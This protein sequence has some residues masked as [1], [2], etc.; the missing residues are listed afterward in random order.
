MN[1]PSTSRSGNRCSAYVARWAAS[2]GRDATAA[3]IPRGTRRRRRPLTCKQAIDL[4]AS[5]EEEDGGDRDAVDEREHADGRSAWTVHR[6]GGSSD[7]AGPLGRTRASGRRGV[8]H[9]VLV[10]GAAAQRSGGRRRRTA[11]SRANRAQARIDR[12]IGQRALRR[13]PRQGYGRPRMHRGRRSRAASSA[14]PVDGAIRR[15][16]AGHLHLA[17]RTRL[18]DRLAARGCAA[19]S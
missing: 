8:V 16:T 10:I 1:R 19:R 5:G 11:N 6:Q 9:A 4:G 18:V 2:F 13:L 17:S 15:A 7:R 3:C 12:R 14:D